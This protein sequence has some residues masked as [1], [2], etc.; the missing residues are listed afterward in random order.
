[1]SAEFRSLCRDPF[2]GCDNGFSGG[3]VDEEGD[4]GEHGPKQN[5]KEAGEELFGKNEGLY[6]ATMHAYLESKDFRRKYR[7]KKDAEI[8]PTTID[9]AARNG[10]VYAR[11]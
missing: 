10:W 2:V 3:E 1:M 5:E 6:C 11:L 4:G 7:G 9:S 8:E